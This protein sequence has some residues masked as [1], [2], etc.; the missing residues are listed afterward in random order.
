MHWLWV[1]CILALNKLYTG[2]EWA[3]CCLLEPVAWPVHS[4]IT[5]CSDGRHSRHVTSWASDSTPAL[6]AHLAAYLLT[7]VGHVIER[8]S[9]EE[10]QQLGLASQAV[11]VYK[12]VR[13]VSAQQCL[14]YLL[15]HMLGCLSHKVD[16][17]PCDGRQ[18]SSVFNGLRLHQ[19]ACE[20]EKTAPFGVNSMRSQ[21]LYQAARGRAW[22]CISKFSY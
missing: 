1:D 17:T 7:L 13:Q 14:R 21:V 9:L 11:T 2:S 10:D 3:V 4:N 22:A 5:E 12:L 15:C 8:G 19:R 18:V 16:L 20:K 6:D